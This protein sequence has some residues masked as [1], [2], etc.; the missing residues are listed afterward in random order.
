[1]NHAINAHQLMQLLAANIRGGKT[2][3][4]AE[5]YSV[6]HI[7]AWA[8]AIEEGGSLEPAD[9]HHRA[10]RTKEAA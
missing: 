5:M 6:N 8:E 1:M 10:M 7:R 9:I 3:S 4:D 2:L